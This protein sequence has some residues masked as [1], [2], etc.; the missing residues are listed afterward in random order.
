MTKHFVRHLNNLYIQD[1]HLVK[2][3]AICNLQ[4]LAARN[5]I[6][7]N[8]Y[9]NTIK[10]RVKI[11]TKYFFNWKLIYAIPCIAT[12]ETKIRIFQCKLLN[13]V[14]YLNKKL[15]HLRIIS[16]FKRFLSELYDETLQHLFY[17]CI[18]A[19]NLWNQL[20]LNLS[21]KVA[22]PVLN[23]QSAIFGFNDVLGNNYLSVNHL[24]SNIKMQRL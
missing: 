2:C 8:S 14:L 3:N 4:K 21:E 20:W 9:W 7:C 19:L 17:E 13:N 6:I 10:L 23:P 15:F 18:N 12:Y 5:S 24:F 11:I 22:L 1:H 16:H